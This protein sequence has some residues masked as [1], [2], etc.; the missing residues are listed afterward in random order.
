MLTTHNAR[1]C[2]GT[3]GGKYCIVPAL[4]CSLRTELLAAG[5]SGGDEDDDSSGAGAGPSMPAGPS[6][7]TSA[8]AK[9]V[10][11]QAKKG[12]PPSLLNSQV[13]KAAKC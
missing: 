9:Y 5:D 10:M 8:R 7:F 6:G 3:T 11:D 13:G 12:Q 4:H 2:G 1:D